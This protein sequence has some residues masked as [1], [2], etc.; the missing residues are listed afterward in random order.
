MKAGGFHK[1]CYAILQ[2]HWLSLQA[3]VTSV[4]IKGHC[5]ASN[6]SFSAC[7]LNEV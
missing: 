3:T 5:E 6:D 2:Y 1:T 4:H 7:Y